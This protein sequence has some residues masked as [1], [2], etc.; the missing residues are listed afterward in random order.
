MVG[1]SIKVDF[2]LSPDSVVSGGS[3]LDRPSEASVKCS[4]VYHVFVSKVYHTVNNPRTHA[5]WRSRR[6]YAATYACRI[7]GS[8]M[9]P[10]PDLSLD[11][12]FLTPLRTRVSIFQ[13]RRQGGYRRSDSRDGCT[14]TSYVNNGRRDCG[15]GEL[16]RSVRWH[17]R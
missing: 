15:Y 1:S 9:G 13:D 7:M 14:S 3:I 16:G 12:V 10:A 5:G 6:S 2:D 4:A 11:L 8:A 17:R